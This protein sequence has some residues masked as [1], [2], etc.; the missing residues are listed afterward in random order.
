MVAGSLS[1]EVLK[2]GVAI[3]FPP[4]QDVRGGQPVGLDVALALAILL[5]AGDEPAW[6]P[7]PWDEVMALLRTPTD[8]DV[9]V[10]MEQTGDRGALYLLGTVLY[11]RRNVLFVL[12]PGPPI[13]SLDDLGGRAVAGDRDAFGEV[14]LAQRG[15]KADVRLVRTPSKELAFDALVARRVEAA[16]MPEAVGRSLAKSL[17]VSVRM[18]DLGDPGTPVGL[19]VRRTRVDLMARLD[20]ATDRLERSGVL[21]NLRDAYLR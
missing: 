11:L 1:A 5:E 9:V 13:R 12:D 2:V 14:E 7:G 21:R 18:V 4:Y 20:A 8:L 3:G 17:G 19:A 6:V 10:G 16:M 15:L